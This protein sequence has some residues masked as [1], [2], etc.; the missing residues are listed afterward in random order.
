MRLSHRPLV[1][2]LILVA[3]AV[4]SCL[5]PPLAQDAAEPSG[6]AA[7]PWPREIESGGTT[8][9]M[10]QPQPEVFEGNRLRA[11]AAV[12][13]TPKGATEPKFGAVWFE[14]RVKTDRQERLVALEEIK[15]ADV[16]F[17]T[18]PK[19]K[20]ELLSNFLK[21][22]LPLWEGVQLSLDRLL[23][24][25]ESAEVQ[26]EAAQELSTD[27]PK[28]VFVT[29][30]TE[31]VI[32]DGQPELRPIDNSALLKV[33]NSV[34]LI[35]LEP[36]SK[37]YF[38]NLDQIWMTAPELQDP[39]KLAEDP[40]ADVAALTPEPDPEAEAEDEGIVPAIMV[41][42]EPMEMITSDG[43]P[44]YSV[45]PDKDLLYMSN[46]DSTVF[47]E[48]ATQDLYSLVAGRW[49]HSKSLDGP[50]NYVRPDALPASFGAIP[51][52]SDVGD[53]RAFVVG[54]EEAQDAV[55]DVQIP[56]TATVP[57][58]QTISVTYDGEPEFEP[59]KETELRRAVNTADSVI[60]VS[61]DGSTLFYCCREGVWYVSSDPTGLYAVAT[62]VPDE[63]NE[64]PPDDP[65]YNTKYVYI[66][67]STPE[68]V[69]VGYTPGYTGTYVYNGTVVYG[70][71][72]TYSGWVGTVYYGYP[73]T[74]GYHAVY[75]PSVGRWF[76]PYSVG[77]V[78]RRTRRRHHRHYHHYHHSAHYRNNVYDH[79]R[80]RVDHKTDR[81]SDQVDRKTDRKSDQVDRRTDQ[82]Q[83]RNNVYADK[84]GNVHRRNENGSWDSRG[85]NGWSGSNQGASSQMKRDYDSRQRGTTRTNSYSGA[86]SQS[87]A[88]AGRSGGG[89]RR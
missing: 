17:P 58:D 11:R 59:I 14:A 54:T 9:A 34:Y 60:Q 75:Y 66:Y 19:E 29:E 61:A 81:K 28:M 46:T 16:R 88:S 55:M 47:R 10:Y 38:L 15:L 64:I 86:R 41:V 65:V 3:L 4:P 51:A 57:R 26:I 44:K 78:V 6:L 21:L 67:G 31:L 40:P 87:R 80:D 39:W 76:S 68:V 20:V 48:L 42:N 45:L 52:D 23:T 89:R 50:W 62:T 37:A 2:L 43:E 22:N 56:Q 5:S 30:P 32:I 27:P 53:T 82:G 49:F 13:V 84:S 18:V 35:L 24:S 69:Y 25:L 70:T 83:N 63:F 79:H 33:I 85:Q 77:G 7:V 73:V 1:V 71:G 12:A 36:Q 72:Y 8:V 74:Y